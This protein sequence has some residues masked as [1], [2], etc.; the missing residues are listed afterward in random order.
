MNASSLMASAQIGFPLLSLLIWLPLVGA[1]LLFLLGRSLP[2]RPLA[3][4]LCVAQVALAVVLVLGFRD[5]T[6]ALQFVEAAGIYRLGVDGLSLWFL[7]LSALLCLL[8]V[9]AHDARKDSAAQAVGETGD[10]AGYLAAVLAFAGCMNGAFAATDTVL[11]VAFFA[12]EVVPSAYL[13]ARHGTGEQR[14]EAARQYVTIMLAASTLVGCALWLMA[15]AGGVTSWAEMGAARL[16]AQAQVLPFLLLLVGLGAKAPLFPL[17]SWLPRVLEQGPMVGMS[18]FLVGLKLGTYAMMR[19]MLPLLPEAVAEWMWLGATLGAASLV[20]GALIAFVQTN[21]RRLLAFA[22]ISHVGVIVLGVFAMNTQGMQGALLQT[23][24]LGLSAAGLFLLA[25]VLESRLGHAQAMTVGGI[26]RA[27]PWLAASFLVVGL[28]GV[29]MPGTSGFN[30]EHLIMI[31]AYKAH[32]A[33]ALAVG[34]GTFLSAAYFLRSYQRAFM[35]GSE[36]MPAVA[37]LGLQEKFVA[38]AVTAVILWVG[39]H[40]TPFMRAITP[41]VAAIEAQIAPRAR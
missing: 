19:F 2:A 35:G 5:E 29:G 8:A 21:L 30:G 16:P 18:V 12:A 11:F 1:A 36:A 31:G 9:L 6:A 4:A 33:M 14:R 3:L 22:S 13:I 37:D 15:G 38:F 10:Q 24:S 17:H 27:A 32:W 28:A 23:M 39:L 40:T 20:Y 25:A 41:T 26:G 34:A 7:P